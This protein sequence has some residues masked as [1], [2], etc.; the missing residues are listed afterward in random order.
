[1]LIP[2]ISF[3]NSSPFSSLFL[4]LLLLSNNTPQG[5]GPWPSFW[6][7]LSP[8]WRPPPR[9][10]WPPPATVKK[11]ISLESTLKYI[12]R[13]LQRR[14]RS[15]SRPSSPFCPVSFSWR[16][17]R[18]GWRVGRDGFGAPGWYCWWSESQLLPSLVW[19]ETYTVWLQIH[20]GGSHGLMDLMK[21][22]TVRPYAPF[23]KQ[24]AYRSRR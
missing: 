19:I 14:H 8:L 15:S 16:Y 4:L 9:G 7:L 2:S 3:F 12:R 22:G 21:L 10:A 18:R 17:A 13:S 23:E 20:S 1:M 11:H 6:P 5:L 24:F